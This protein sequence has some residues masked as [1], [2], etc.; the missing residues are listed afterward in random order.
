[1]PSQGQA[2]TEGI[3]FVKA[4]DIGFG[5]LRN[6][7]RGSP[8]LS[9]ARGERLVCEQILSGAST[10]SLAGGFQLL[11]GEGAGL[12]PASHAPGFS[13]ACDYGYSGKSG[14]PM[15][16]FHGARSTTTEGRELA[17]N[18]HPNLFYASRLHHNLA[19]RDGGIN[20]PP[21]FVK[22]VIA[23]PAV[24]GLIPVHCTRRRKHSGQEGGPEVSR[25]AAVWTP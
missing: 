19:L 17:T 6:V 5:L 12:Y 16:S 9:G 24:D 13:V 1:M 4:G 10:S 20:T 2:V 15:P 11:G 23:N 3:E 22:K 8:P 25:R 14:D 18:G 21:F 7:L